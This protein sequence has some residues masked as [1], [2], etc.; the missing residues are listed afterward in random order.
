MRRLARPDLLTLLEF[1]REIYALRDPEAFGAHVVA[2]LPKV[3]RSDIT[4]FNEV[5]PRGRRVRWMTHPPDALDFRGSVAVFERVMPEHP[6]IRHYART[7][8]G[9]ALKISD[10]LSRTQFHRLALYHE[11]YRPLDVEHQMAVTLPARPPL[12]IGIALNRSRRDFSEADRLLL[13]L[14][15]P[16]LVQAW[17]TAEAFARTERELALFRLVMAAERR[18]ALPLGRDG[19][20]RWMTPEAAGLLARYFGRP[21]AAGALPE[22]LRRWVLEGR[23]RLAGRD[24][25]PDPI[26]PLTVAR[27]TGRVVARLLPGRDE[28]V[29]VLEEESLTPNLAGLEALGLTRREA[30]VLGW[31]AEGKTNAE[32]A[33]IL[34]ASVGTV[35][36]HTERIYR[37]LGVETRTAAARL[38]L[39]ATGQTRRA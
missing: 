28:D 31:I 1:L 36:K 26:T 21:S 15:R 7:G 12:V 24:D 8:D 39:G 25:A 6:L 32:I 30:E 5:D 18:V 37:K 23:A 33:A 9:R 16:H 35:K 34:G 27:E 4:S 22:D 10:F 19:R 17:Q 38:A 11:F 20:V 29:L 3:V 2:A 13:N 14:L